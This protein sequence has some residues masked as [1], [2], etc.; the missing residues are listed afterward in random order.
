MKLQND[1]RGVTLLETMLA[2]AV[3]VSIFVFGIR[4]YYQFSFQSKEQQI[5][6]N[7]SQLFQAMS[8]YYYAN[9]REARNEQSQPQSSGALDPVNSDKSEIPEYIELSV[10]KDLITPGFLSAAAWHPENSLLDNYSPEDQRYEVQFN[11]I[12]A[13]NADPVMTVYTC[14]GKDKSPSC[15]VVS[16]SVLDSSERP[17]NQTRVITWVVQVAVKLDAS[18]SMEERTQIKND[19]NADCISTGWATSVAACRT[20]PQAGSYLVWTRMPSAYSPGVTSNNWASLPYVKQ[21]NMQYTNDGMA[22]LSGVKDETENWYDPLNYLC[23]G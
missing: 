17:S 22:A 2:I 3:A 18:L 21:F 5:A 19:L 7:V 20:N 15:D 14:A 9:C 10:Q 6:R 16:K 8:S 1:M 12:L 11:R 23:G 13:G 4:L